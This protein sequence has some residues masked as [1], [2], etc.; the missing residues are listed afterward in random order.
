MAYSDKKSRLPSSPALPWRTRIQL[1]LLSTFTNASRRSDGTVN[2]RLLRFLGFGLRTTANP[3]P[4]KG[5]ST[6]DV[7]IDSSRNLWFRLFVPTQLAEHDDSQLPVVIFFHGGG[8]VF[9]SPDVKPYD[10]ICR[11]FAR[12]FPA[13]VIS[14]NYRLAPEHRY[15][16]QYEDCFDVLKF[17]HNEKSVLPENANLSQCFLAGDSAGGNLSHHVAKR[18]CESKFKTIKIIGVMA[19]QPFF[20]G[21]ERTK[22]EIELEGIDPLLSASR[23]E[24]AWKSFMPEG[25]GMDRDH[26]VI[27]VSG[28]NAADISQLDFP[29]TLVVVAGFDS[30]QDWQRRYY[31]WLKHNGKEAY[32]LEYPN[33][34]HAFYLYPE[35]PETDHLFS[36]LKDF[37]HKHC[38]K[39]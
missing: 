29:S 6:S 33:T 14:V 10:V 37:I 39:K 26:E 16:A 24:W 32:L 12:E 13:V 31:E 38:E 23:T 2:R 17:L 15:P 21:E 5:V 19:I 30:L 4:T 18:A 36:Q 9:L 28:K 7:T 1:S 25:E 11:R 20:G 8:F 35:L 3:N 22:A 27:N 34:I